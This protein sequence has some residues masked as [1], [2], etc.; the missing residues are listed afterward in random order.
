MFVKMSI[1]VT[2][3]EDFE[4]ENYNYS[5]TLSGS[6]SSLHQGNLIPVPLSLTCLSYHISLCQLTI[7]TIHNALTLLLPA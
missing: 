6:S 5:E 2:K 3:I 1:A 4:A 7:L